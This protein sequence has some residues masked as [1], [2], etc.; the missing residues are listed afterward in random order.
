[1]RTLAA[2][3][4]H[5]NERL[6]QTLELWTVA[7]AIADEAKATAAEA[8]LV[9]DGAKIAADTA[10]NEADE[11]RATADRANRAK[12]EFLARMSHELRTPM[13]GIIGFTTIVL[14]SDL[15]SEQHRHLTHLRDAGK[16][17]MAIINDIL[18]FSKIEAGKLE[19]EQIALCPRD[20]VD[21]A[22][23]I[24]RADALARGL[25]VDLRVASDVPDWV[26]GDPTRLRQILLNLLT[27][28]L[29]FT[30]RGTIS[31]RLRRDISGDRSRLHFEVTDTGVGIALE[32]QHLLFQDF[33]QISTATSRQYGG[34]G[35]G[36]AISQRLVQAMHGTIGVTSRPGA[37]ST[38]W[39]S[40]LLAATEAPPVERRSVS[41]SVTRRVLV[42]DDNN[43][44]Q[45]VVEALLSKDGHAVVLASDG[46]QAVAAVQTGDFD[47]V[48]MDMLMPVLDGIDATRAIR[49]LAGS[50]SGIPIIA[51]TAN[52]MTDDVQR[53]RDAGMNAHLSKPVDR[54]L[55]R[56]ALAEWGGRRSEVF[57]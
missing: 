34:T 42:V 35:L 53:C 4:R 6:V 2:Q 37:G 10:R 9:A 24:I 54:E 31:L 23:A 21:G 8:K 39:F 38:F 48:L 41:R 1:V 20:E 18:D 22:L 27:N 15:N 32:K 55:L 57:K 5:E 30:A 26:I 49:Q 56:K 28:A 13:N 19:I 7:K 40:A 44:N 11:A 17:L 46:A 43:I 14:D 45:I 47:L 12:S 33:E 50:V 36:L 52:A 29:K 16:S 25:D 3:L 51:L